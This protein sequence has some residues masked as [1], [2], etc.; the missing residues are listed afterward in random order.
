MDTTPTYQAIDDRTSKRPAARKPTVSFA[1]V[2]DEESALRYLRDMIRRNDYKTA[3]DTAVEAGGEKARLLANAIR[4]YGMCRL[5]V[6]SPHQLLIDWVRLLSSWRYSHQRLHPT[7]KG[8]WAWLVY[9]T[10]VEVWHLRG[11]SIHDRR[12]IKGPHSLNWYLRTNRRGAR[13]EQN[14]FV[15]CKGGVFPPVPEIEG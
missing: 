15:A 8:W 1:R 10:E 9:H 2:D 7:K 14:G 11:P 4:S 6:P 13:I 5:M 3:I 12:L